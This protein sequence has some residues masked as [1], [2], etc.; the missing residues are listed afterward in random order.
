MDSLFWS[1]FKLPRG[2]C[3][4]IPT[5]LENSPLSQ[6]GNI[7]YTR[8]HGAVKTAARTP[9][10]ILCKKEVEFPARTD[11]CIYSPSIKRQR[12]LCPSG[13]LETYIS[14]NVC[15]VAWRKFRPFLL[16]CMREQKL[17][18]MPQCLNTSSGHLVPCTGRQGTSPAKKSEA[19][20]GFNFGYTFLHHCNYM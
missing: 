12:V 14:K 16:V 1:A 13:I 7:A 19:K 9:L 18:I 2:G 6:A 15:A 17:N 8:K 10:P 3:R 4:G 20:N 5:A 11:K